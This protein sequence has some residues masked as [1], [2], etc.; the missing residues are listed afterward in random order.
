MSLYL[1]HKQA[2]NLKCNAC[3]IGLQKIRNCGGRFN[4][5]AL[6]K[7]N[8]EI[9]RQC[10]RSYILGNYELKYLTELYFDCRENK[11][12]PFKGTMRDQTAY[13]VDFFQYAD[14]LISEKRAKEYDRQML[15]IE[16]AKQK[17]NKGK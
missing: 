9:Y 13:C 17:A 16:K 11:V 4:K 6:I 8:D 2:R 7:I 1:D 10:P 15:D 5:P 12:W 14:S 3:D